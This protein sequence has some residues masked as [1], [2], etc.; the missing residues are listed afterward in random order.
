M[1]RKTSRSMKVPPMIQTAVDMGLSSSCA[2]SRRESITMT[3]NRIELAAISQ[4]APMGAGKV[5]GHS[6]R[7]AI[8]IELTATYK[9][10]RLGEGLTEL[11]IRRRGQ[12]LCVFAGDSVVTTCPFSQIDQFAAF[13]AKREIGMV[14]RR[15]SFANRAASSGNHNI[16]QW[17]PTSSNRAGR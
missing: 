9:L 6:N 11:I 10:V 5:T 3:T 14:A 13:A 12:K 8:T 4:L 7:N 15:L 17:E 16:R 2:V 1:S